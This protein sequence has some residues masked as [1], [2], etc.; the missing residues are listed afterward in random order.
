MPAYNV[1]KR[2]TL[3]RLTHRFVARSRSVLHEHM[4][5]LAD[6][7]YDS[8]E[9]GDHSF[10]PRTGDLDRRL[11]RVFQEHRETVTR[12]AASDAVQEIAENPKTG[13]L[14]LWE[15]YDEQFPV[16]K[17]PLP[18]ELAGKKKD[19]EKKVIQRANKEEPYKPSTLTGT[20]KSHYLDN[21]R[22]IYRS[23]SA[24]WLIGESHI[25][26]VVTALQVALQKTEYEA[27]RIF[28]TETT[29]YF[30]ETRAT[31]FAT[32]TS[33]DYIQ[34]YAVTDGRISK[35]CE[36]RH[37][38]VV[39]IDQAKLKKYM[40]AFH[41][42]CRTIQRPL[43]SRLPSNKVRIDRGLRLAEHESEWTPLPKG[44]A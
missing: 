18:V 21:L 5:G 26:D 36:D 27:V 35:I 15:S 14:G 7:I 13:R 32:Q 31:Y 25:S 28:R 1:H 20:L 6:E 22:K 3:D 30:N 43:M 19:I 24:R 33:V 41:P 11:E 4:K 8:L 34:L 38:A 16:E 37:E 9:S 39:P 17:I 23:L 42:H 44:W 2:A 10:K 12:V 29:T 40:P